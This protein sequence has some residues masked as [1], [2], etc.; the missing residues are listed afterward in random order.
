[1]ARETSFVVGY[2]GE[3]NKEEMIYGKYQKDRIDVDGEG[4]KVWE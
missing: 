1:L 2:V 4:K 3:V